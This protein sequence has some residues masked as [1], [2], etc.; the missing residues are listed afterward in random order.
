MPPRLRPRFEVEVACPSQQVLR[1]LDAQLD[2]PDG[3]CRGNVVGRHAMLHIRDDLRHTWSPYLDLEV[4]PHGEGALLRGRFGP[5]PSIWSF[6]AALYAICAFVA[7]GGL[8]VGLSQLSLGFPAWGLWAVPGALVL[9]AVVY[10]VALMG[11]RLAQEQMHTLQDV[12]HRAAG[13]SDADAAAA[14][15]VPDTAART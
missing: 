9:A 7:L 4:E 13:L 3:P 11:Q 10:A 5:H 2:D 12:L 8:I 15:P 6:F 14:Q 1:Q